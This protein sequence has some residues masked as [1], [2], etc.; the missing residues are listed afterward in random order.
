[1]TEPR[2]ISEILDEILPGI[3]SKKETEEAESI[4]KPPVLEEVLDE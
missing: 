4:K 1:M 3:L 2:H